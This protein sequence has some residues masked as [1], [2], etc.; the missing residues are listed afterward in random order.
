MKIVIFIILLIIIFNTFY[1]LNLKRKQKLSINRIKYIRNV[2]YIKKVIKS[3]NSYFQLLNSYNWAKDYVNNYKKFD[4]KYKENNI[5]LAM[6]NNLF[7]TR[8]FQLEKP[9]KHEIET[10][11]ERSE[12]RDKFLRKGQWLFN[13]LYKMYPNFANSIRGTEFDPFYDDNRINKF[14]NY[15]SN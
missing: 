13:E 9:T 7:I 10:I 2:Y 12:N 14:I 15:I 5:D 11:L 8:R 4:V 1:K 3:C 6:I